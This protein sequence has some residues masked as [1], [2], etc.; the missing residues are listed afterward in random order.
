MEAKHTATPWAVW[1]DPNGN[2]VIRAENGD[3]IARPCEY[4]DQSEFPF[5]HEHNAAFIVRACNAH[6]A[7]VSALAEL[8][9]EK[10]PLGIDRSTYQNALAALDKAGSA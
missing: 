3:N 5:G 1:S 8:V 9:N 2:I 6:D 10:Q 7:L 4:G